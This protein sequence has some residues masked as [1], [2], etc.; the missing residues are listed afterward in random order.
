MPAGWEWKKLGEVCE[1]VGGGTP[2]KDNPQFYKGNIL[3]ATV[4]DMKSE[5]I[6]QTEF[7]ISEEAVKKS[8]TNIIPKGNVVIATRV[9]LGKVCLIEHDTAINQDLR[10]LIPKKSNQ[11]DTKYLFHWFKSVSHLVVQEGTGATVQGVKLPFIKSLGIPLP[12]L[13]EQ[14]RIVAFLD[15]AFAAIARAKAHAEQNLQNAKALFE[16][17]LQGVFAS[18]GSATGGGEWEVKKL[19]EVVNNIMTGPFG[20]MLHQSDYVSEGIPVVNPQ[21]IVDGKIIPITKTMIN[22]ATF[23]RLEKYALKLGDIVIARRGEMGRCAVVREE[24]INWLCGTGSFVIRIDPKRAD[25]DFLN[26]F[27]SSSAV[28]QLLEKESIGATMSNLNQTILF[29]LPI[30]IPPLETQQTIVRQL[31]ALHA[32]TQRLEAVYRQKLEDLEELKKSVLAKAFR[33]ELTEAN[34]SN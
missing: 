21:N 17:Y 6:S 25:S 7:C 1:I 18:T 16:S 3:W 27:L 8:S 14:Q 32:E 23:M 20:S 19:G 31:D 33:G 34:L 24:N 2:S 4:R 29:E 13:P 11:L 22:Q 28:K 10:G 5:I 9:G 12:P 15:E 30:K 26:L